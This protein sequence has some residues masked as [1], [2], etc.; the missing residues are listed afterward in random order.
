MHF[1]FGEI[2]FRWGS[3]RCKDLELVRHRVRDTE[4]CVAF[5]FLET[6]SRWK[7]GPLE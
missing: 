6:S 5:P 2:G 3:S 4:L 7:G 1:I